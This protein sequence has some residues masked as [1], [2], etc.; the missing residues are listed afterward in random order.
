M[1]DIINEKLKMS[2]RALKIKID[3]QVALLGMPNLNRR[4]SPRARFKFVEL[5]SSFP[6]SRTSL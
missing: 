3:V 2:K 4:E 6:R 5:G 1:L